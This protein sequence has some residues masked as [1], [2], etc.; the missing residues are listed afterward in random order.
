MARKRKKLGNIL[1]SWGVVSE[2]NLDDAIKFA[3][4]THRRLGDALVEMNLVDEAHEFS[5][6][7]AYRG[8]RIVNA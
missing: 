5:V 2:K 3:K 8:G 1:L 7:I 4:N 6:G